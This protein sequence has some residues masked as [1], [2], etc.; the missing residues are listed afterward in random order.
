MDFF[1]KAREYANF[2]KDM[3]IAA[4]FLHKPKAV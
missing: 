1:D 3:K 2:G 4:A